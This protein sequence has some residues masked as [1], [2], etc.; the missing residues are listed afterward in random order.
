VI[1]RGCHPFSRPFRSLIHSSH[2]TWLLKV[3]MPMSTFTSTSVGSF[4]S[5]WFLLN[6]G[7]SP[8]HSCVFCVVCFDLSHSNVLSLPFFVVELSMLQ[9][10]KLT[11]HVWDVSG[12]FWQFCL[13]LQY[14]FYLSTVPL[15]TRARRTTRTLRFGSIDTISLSRVIAALSRVLFN[16]HLIAISTRCQLA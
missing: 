6:V 15:F 12:M 13:F 3:L 10:H 4:L 7:D 8:S 1:Y 11:S 9:F 16:N 14:S 5:C 2:P